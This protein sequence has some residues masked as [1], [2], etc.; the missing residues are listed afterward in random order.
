MK[1]WPINLILFLIFIFAG[2]IIGRLFFLQVIKADFYSALAQGQNNNFLKIQGDRG[3]IFLKDKNE[4]LYP[5]GTNRDGKFCFLFLDEIKKKEEIADSLSKILNLD[6]EDLLLEFEKDSGFFVL[7]E[8]LTSEEVKNLE[9]SDIEE[10]KISDQKIREYPYGELASDVIGF[11]NEDGDGQYGIE[12]YYDEELRGQERI[13]ESKKSHGGYLSFFNENEIKGSDL[14]LT[15]DY[16]IQFQAE[17]LLKKAEENYNI[18]G[19]Q[20]IV[21]DPYSG[22]IL[23]MADFPSFNP[24]SYSSYDLGIFKNNAIQEL[25]EPGSIFKA[26]TMS[27]SLNED[28]ITP[29]TTYDDPGMLLI[30]GWPIYNYEQRN[31]GNN[32]TM[33]EVLEKS[34][35]TGA[36]FAEEKLGHDDFSR[37]LE[38]FGIFKKT[39]IDLAGESYSSNEE[40]KKG[41]DVNFVTA[42]FGQG[43]EMTPIQI[44]RAFS[45]IANGGKEINPYIV[46]K[47][48][49]NGQVTELEPVSEERKII[50]PMTSSKVTAMLVS[51]VENGFSKG[52]QVSGYYIAGKTG[53]SQISYASLG[54]DRKGYSDETWQT[55]IGYAPAFNPRFLVLVKLDNPAAKTASYS[56]IPIF[57]ELAGYIIDYLEIPPDY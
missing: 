8:D 18:R 49:K 44:V 27:S 17:K 38:S 43:I 20:I 23:A 50:F 51:V 16:N 1:N 39:N 26:I 31:Y 10:I 54:E 25:F 24:N 34:I 40:F 46:E 30:G 15:L 45:A 2:V 5:V 33:T 42:S 41:Y 47:T 6:K 28:K 29:Q 11:I 32:I 19:G 55:F 56:A 52:A 53:T 35:N 13:L 3:K 9:E 12:E 36:V 7:K 57:Q 22:K 21:A 14:V 48:V 37:Y 4:N